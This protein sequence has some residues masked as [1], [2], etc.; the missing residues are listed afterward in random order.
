MADGE[1]VEETRQQG[2]TARCRG[3]G[4][5]SA[6]VWQRSPG[7][8]RNTDVT[9]VPVIAVILGKQTGWETKR[10]PMAALAPSAGGQTPSSNW[11]SRGCPPDPPN[12]STPP[13]PPGAGAGPRGKQTGLGSLVGGE[14]EAAGWGSPHGREDALRCQRVSWSPRLCGPR[15][16]LLRA[17]SRQRG[18]DDGQETPS[19]SK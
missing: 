8:C 18:A 7:C 17:Q 2:V 6:R 13:R 9:S 10:L 19:P 11:T 14:Q 12:S 1:R 5:G 15:V 3:A 16:D 4:W